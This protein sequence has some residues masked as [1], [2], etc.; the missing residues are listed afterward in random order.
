[1]KEIRDTVERRKH[2]RVAVRHADLRVA[3]ATHFQVESILD[4]SLGGVRLEISAPRVE[5]KVGMLVD[6]R[7]EW[8]EAS[9]V[10]NGSLRH[11]EKVPPR[12]GVPE[13]YS[14]G[15]EFDDPDLVGQL[16]GSWYA[17]EVTSL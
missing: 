6:I 17:D 10:V 11:F 16:L 7:L 14:I 8:Q 1:M 9:A 4:V 12:G 5:L 15:L 2:P 13:R 3:E